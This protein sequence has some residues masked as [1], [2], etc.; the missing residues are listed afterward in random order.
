MAIITDMNEYV[1]RRQGAG[2]FDSWP[3]EHLAARYAALK[4]WDGWGDK[5]PEY[6]FLSFPEGPRDMRNPEDN[7]AV[8]AAEMKRR[9]MKVS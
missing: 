7:T 1:A 6:A 3:D 8:I 2:H 9:G 5:M 4:V